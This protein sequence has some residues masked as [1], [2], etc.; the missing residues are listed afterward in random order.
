MHVGLNCVQ[1]GGV[2]VGL[3]WT[4]GQMHG[5]G[6]CLC[7]CLL[8]LLLLS[9]I[10]GLQGDKGGQC[11]CGGGGGGGE[12]QWASVGLGCEGGGM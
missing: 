7:R 1:G 2:S 11:V 6:T 8:L 3:L 12:M 5:T 4:S 10:G 9:G